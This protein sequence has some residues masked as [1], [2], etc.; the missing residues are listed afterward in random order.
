M[1]LLGADLIG[2]YYKPGV[3]PYIAGDDSVRVSS[4]HNSTTFK[5]HAIAVPCRGI[6]EVSAELRPFCV[7]FLDPDRPGWYIVIRPGGTL[8]FEPEYAPTNPDTFDEDTAFIAK[9]DGFF[10]GFGA[11]G[12]LVPN[13]YVVA[14]PD[15]S[16]LRVAEFQNTS[17][18]KEATGYKILDY[19]TKGETTNVHC[20]SSTFVCPITVAMCS[21]AGS[22]PVHFAEFHF[23]QTLL[24]TPTPNHNPNPR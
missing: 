10:P 20:M 3:M 8:Y 4:H 18:F 9:E 2:A 7:A 13:H 17:D 1:V 14:G 21:I 16:I 23:A 22:V 11:F 5:N 19:S 24:H 12:L 6:D 15:S